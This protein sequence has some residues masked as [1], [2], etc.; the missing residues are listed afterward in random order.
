MLGVVA[1]LASASALAAPPTLD[2]QHLPRL[3]ERGLARAV[4]AGV[5]LQTMRGQALGVLKRL[6]LAP[7]KATSSGLIMRNGRGDLFVIDLYERRVRRVYER[8]E[9]VPG[10]RVT[11][12][13][14]GLQLLA[15]R[16]TIKTRT[17]GGR[18]R[19]VARAPGRIGHWERA[20]FAPHGNV[21]FAQWS[22]ECEVPVA[23]L[24]VNG[25]MRPYGGRTIRDAPSSMAL[26]WLPDGSAVI[27][28]PTGACGGSYRNP[29][30]YAVPLRGKAQ[31]LV[32]TPRTPRFQ[33]YWM[34][35]G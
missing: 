20:A 26:G 6:H 22:A 35:G 4:P 33:H 12:A 7:D 1:V 13:R 8:P 17:D 23:F 9:P 15:Y 24:V 2:L 27:H 28:Y 5:E 25:V 14:P 11:D 21:F 3:P 18:L 31:V 16:S 34:W 30:V 10:C 32:R 19:V 29:G